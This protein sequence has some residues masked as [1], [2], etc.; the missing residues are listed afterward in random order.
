MKAVNLVKTIL[1]AVLTVLAITGCSQFV[2]T[3]PRSMEVEDI[4]NMT[5]AGVGSDVIKRQIE[6]TNSKFR[7]DA[8]QII[9]LKKNG[10]EDKILEVMIDSGDV[11]EH[12]DWEYGY[13]YSPYDYWTN[14]YNNWYPT[15]SYYPYRYP[16]TVYRRSGLLGRFYR[17]APTYPS[18][19]DYQDQRGIYPGPFLREEEE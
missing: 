8:D 3:S 11:P 13:G 1:T 18:Y 6:V 15:Y 17:Y 10:V 5:K 16:Y 2:T 9:Q 19:G 4:I 14:Y 7:L 12:F